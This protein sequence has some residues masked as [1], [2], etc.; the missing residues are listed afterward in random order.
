MKKNLTTIIFI[1]ISIILLLLISNKYE[2]QIFNKTV[3]ACILAQKQK[4][5]E[6]NFKAAEK[7]CKEEIKKKINKSK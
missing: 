3:S 5:E 4:N 6:Y 7:F 2:K 1:I